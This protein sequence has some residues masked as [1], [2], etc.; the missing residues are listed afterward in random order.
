MT[1]KNGQM[2]IE[3]VG[4]ND[5]YRIFNRLSDDSY[6]LAWLPMFDHKNKTVEWAQGYYDMTIKEASDLFNE[7]VRVLGEE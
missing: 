6:I 3:S 5:V 7:K 2:E 4:G 1:Y